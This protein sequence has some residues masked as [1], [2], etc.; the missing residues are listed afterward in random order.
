MNRLIGGLCYAAEG[1]LLELQLWLCCT[2]FPLARCATQQAESQ[3]VA[4]ELAVQYYCSWAK[5]AL[6]LCPR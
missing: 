1:L 5:P 6:H 2:T 4:R 3:G